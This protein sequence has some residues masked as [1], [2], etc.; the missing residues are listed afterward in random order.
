MMT[1]LCPGNRGAIHRKASGG[2]ICITPILICSRVHGGIAWGFHYGRDDVRNR[3]GIGGD[4]SFS[5]PR[6]STLNLQSTDS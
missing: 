5:A 4:G 3:E 1:Y 2:E 6:G